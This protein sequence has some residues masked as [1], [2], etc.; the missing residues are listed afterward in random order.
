MR[1]L[2]ARKEKIKVCSNNHSSEYD[3]RQNVLDIKSSF[4]QQ[5][6]ECIEQRVV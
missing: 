3:L 6:F 2:L 5:N 1:F 4:H